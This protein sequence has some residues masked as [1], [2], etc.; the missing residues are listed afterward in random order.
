MNGTGLSI[1]GASD[2]PPGAVLRSEEGA[3]MS[4]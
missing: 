1:E 3:E 4:L 2:V